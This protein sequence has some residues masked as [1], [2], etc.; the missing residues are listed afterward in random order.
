MKEKQ[1]KIITKNR[2]FSTKLIYASSFDCTDNLTI[3]LINEGN[4]KIGLILNGVRVK[5]NSYG[6]KRGVSM[7][8]SIK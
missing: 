6:I 7:Y 4:I 8:L 2:L 1:Q 3:Q 5:K